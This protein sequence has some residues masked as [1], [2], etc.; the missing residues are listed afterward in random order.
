[1]VRTTCLDIVGGHC[2]LQELKDLCK[3]KEKSKINDW[4]PVIIVHLIIIVGTYGDLSMKVEKF[5]PLSTCVW[6]SE[7]IS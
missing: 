1:M 4:I 2:Y 3:Q 5:Y 7:T 6:E